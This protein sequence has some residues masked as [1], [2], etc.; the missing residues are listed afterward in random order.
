MFLSFQLLTLEISKVF[1]W[2]VEYKVKSKKCFVGLVHQ[3]FFRKIIRT[4]R[5]GVLDNRV[6]VIRQNVAV[7]KWWYLVCG[8][9]P[10]NILSKISNLAN[11]REKQWCKRPEFWLGASLLNSHVYQ[12]KD[13]Y[14]FNWCCSDKQ[15]GK[16][17][18][19]M[20]EK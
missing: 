6:E 19:N 9:N 11:I 15:R 18:K 14:Q 16:H 20:A 8:V 1:V 7:E 2:V 5:N 17:F 10:T 12:R 13:I 4:K 3:L